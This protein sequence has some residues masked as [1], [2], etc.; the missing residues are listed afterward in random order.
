MTTP[1][2]NPVTYLNIP[3]SVSAT[4]TAFLLIPR[5]YP[6]VSI[7]N[8]DISN[9]LL[10]SP[11]PTPVLTNSVPVP[12]LTN[13]QFSGTNG[14][15]Y[16]LAATNS[17]AYVSVS[18]ATVNPSP[19]QIAEQIALYGIPPYVPNLSFASETRMTTQGSPYT[20][21]QF[22]SNG[23]IWFAQIS[24]GVATDSTYNSSNDPV[25][26]IYLG[27]LSQT[28]LIAQ[29]VTAGPDQICSHDPSITIPGLPITA[30]TTVF[31]DVNGG[32]AVTDLDQNASCVIGYSIP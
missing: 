19:A 10:V 24:Y 9:T 22:P 23:R 15:L 14:P 25:A 16:A 27:A 30:G 26:R 21:F 3:S 7:Y 2:I 12:P 20:V 4:G 1:I 32:V 31:A 5:G 18:N 6:S 8:G 29:A 28:L 11:S 13:A 17:V